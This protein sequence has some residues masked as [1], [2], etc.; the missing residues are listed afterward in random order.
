M[1]KDPSYCY[2][3]CWLEAIV[4]LI[5]AGVGMRYGSIS[6]LKK[7]V[8]VKKVFLKVQTRLHEKYDNFFRM[9]TLSRRSRPGIIR[10]AELSF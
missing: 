4:G 2:K 7:T 3:F 5:F 8:E 6:R 10:P 1:L 9:Q